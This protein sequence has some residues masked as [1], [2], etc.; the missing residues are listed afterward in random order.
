M[1]KFFPA[2]H[3]PTRTRSPVSLQFRSYKR[4]SCCRS[5]RSST[6]PCCRILLPTA[7]VSSGCSGGS[8][9]NQLS[10]GPSRIHLW[11]LRDFL[12][13][14]LYQVRSGHIFPKEIKYQSQGA[15]ISVTAQMDKLHRQK[16]IPRRLG[17][18]TFP[19]GSK[20]LRN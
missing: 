2:Y 1:N 8:S 9:P 6:S 20:H 5:S 15:E 14:K 17:T 7:N 19:D 18:K 4:R 11:K 12:P 13:S 3:P 16:S 10:P